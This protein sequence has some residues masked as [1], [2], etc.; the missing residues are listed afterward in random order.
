M[1]ICKKYNN[2]VWNLFSDS[3]HNGYFHLIYPKFQRNK[4][5]LT[6]RCNVICKGLPKYEIM[7][8]IITKLW[9]GSELYTKNAI[10][11]PNLSQWLEISTQQRLFH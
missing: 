10:Y 5:C 2:K 9:A 1:G 11:G 8:N 4:D 6:K 7:Q 3:Y